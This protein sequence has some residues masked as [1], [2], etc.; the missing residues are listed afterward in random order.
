M[1]QHT[2]DP[3]YLGLKP[4]LSEDG[5]V[6]IE[7]D[8]ALESYRQGGS[9]FSRDGERLP[10]S[11]QPCHV[12]LLIVHHSCQTPAPPEARLQPRRSLRRSGVPFVS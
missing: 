3:V 10:N 4:W 7:R 12:A 9:R 1:I 6:G 8:V 5:G 2:R 11:P